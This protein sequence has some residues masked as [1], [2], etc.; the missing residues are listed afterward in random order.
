MSKYVS[1]AACIAGFCIVKKEIAKSVLDYCIFLGLHVPNS[2]CDS[3]LSSLPSCDQRISSSF[4]NTLSLVKD[5]RSLKGIEVIYPEIPNDWKYGP[6][7]FV[8]NVK[9]PHAKLGSSKTK[10][11]SALKNGCG[12]ADL[13]YETSFGSS[14]CK[15]DCFPVVQDNRL[16]L[17]F[18]VGYSE[19]GEKILK[20][21]KNVLI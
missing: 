13:A 7:V 3:I 5:L 11:V 6:S 2:T 1:A 15:L 14:H 10:I 20:F 17:R 8:V 12:E 9:I 19:D 4:S 21:V 16:Q 18:S